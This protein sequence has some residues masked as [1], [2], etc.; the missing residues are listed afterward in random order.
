MHQQGQRQA[1]HGKTSRGIK[2]FKPKQNFN[3]PILTATNDCWFI[4][5]LV[6]NPSPLSW[7]SYFCYYV[8]ITYQPHTRLFVFGRKPSKHEDV[9]INL[10][11]FSFSF[12]SQISP[13]MIKMLISRTV[14]MIKP[15]NLD[16][17]AQSWVCRQI[18]LHL[19]TTRDY[20][21]RLGN[22][23]VSGGVFSWLQSATSP[24][25]ATKPYILSL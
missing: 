11:C 9:L 8:H 23:G 7:P 21:T 14:P 19:M 13:K 20:N 5:I 1:Q 3:N 17:Y 2:I 22:G 10:S 16:A 18:L 6:R 25:D 15:K 4:R 12:A 24:L